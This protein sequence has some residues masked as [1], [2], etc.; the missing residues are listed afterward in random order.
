M[1]QSIKIKEV[2]NL[3]KITHKCVI[4]TCLQ[5]SPKAVEDRPWF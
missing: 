2:R 5:N 4:F 1:E 3:N